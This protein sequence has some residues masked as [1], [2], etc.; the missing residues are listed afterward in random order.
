M[1]LGID[2]G[3]TGTTAVVFDNSLSPIADGYAK[4]SRRTPER[5]LVEVEPADLLTSVQEAVADALAT[6][7]ASPENIEAIGLANQGETSMCWQPDGDPI[8]TALVWQDRRTSDR[9]AELTADGEFADYVQRTTGLEIDPY[10]SATKLEWLLNERVDDSAEIRCG[11]TDAWLLQQLT[12]EGAYVTDHATASRTML[13]DITEQTW[14]TRLVKRFGLADTSLPMPIPNDEVVGH[15]DSAVLGGVDAPIAGP[16]VDQQSALYGQAC[17]DEGDA[18]C[19]YG[20]GNFLLLN[21]GPTAVTDAEGVV[22]TLAWTLDDTTDYALDGG[23]YTTGA[24]IDWF[25]ENA[26][27]LESPGKSGELAASVTDSNG[28]CVVPALTGLAAP[29]WD[30]NARAAF[31]GV[32]ASTT[33]AHLIRAALEGIAHR[34]R[35]VCERMVTEAGLDLTELRVDGGLTANDFLMQYQANTLGCDITVSAEPEATALGAAALAGRALDISVDTTGIG[36]VERTVRPDDDCK[37]YDESYR[38]WRLAVDTIRTWTHRE[39]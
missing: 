26:Q 30:S 38:R 39:S 28:V 10:F 21:T 12:V 33:R 17:H 31:L 29:Y 16:I 14:D 22:G 8:G 2:Q 24:F 18:K 9:C 13:F 34:V 23:I 36:S 27:L 5:G 4:V 1:L 37:G 11:T 32:G 19:T 7:E 3:T 15:A 6:E 25:V 35:D 20:T